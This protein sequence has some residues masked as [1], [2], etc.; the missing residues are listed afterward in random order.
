MGRYMLTVGAVMA[1][2]FMSGLTWVGH[3]SPAAVGL[4]LLTSGFGVLA[5]ARKIADGVYCADEAA[6]G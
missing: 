3:V 5:A 6:Q 1:D 4:T 2:A